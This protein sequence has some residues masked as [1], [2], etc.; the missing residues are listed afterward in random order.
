MFFHFFVVFCLYRQCFVL[1]FLA[2]SVWS[3]PLHCLS[4]EP[5]EELSAPPAGVIVF[6]HTLRS[7]VAVIAQAY[8]L[9]VMLL[10]IA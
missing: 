6:R 7:I 4:R 8:T 10:R 3:G 1:S 2:T 5:L 9:D